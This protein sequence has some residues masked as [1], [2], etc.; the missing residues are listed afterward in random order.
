M[1]IYSE[2]ERR[3][4]EYRDTLFLEG[5]TPQQILAAAHRQMI[6]A[7]TKDEDYKIIIKS[8]VKAK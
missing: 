7:A 6:E 1:S 2:W 5:Y 4:P 8:E 3:L